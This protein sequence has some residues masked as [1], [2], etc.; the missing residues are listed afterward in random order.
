MFTPGIK[1]RRIRDLVGNQRDVLRW[2][3]FRGKPV[4]AVLACR[5]CIGAVCVHRE[6]VGPRGFRARGLR[7]HYPLA[8][9]R[10]PALYY[11]SRIRRGLRWRALHF[12]FR[13][14]ELFFTHVALACNLNGHSH[15]TA[16]VILYAIP[17]AAH[18]VRGKLEVISDIIL[19]VAFRIIRKSLSTYFYFL[20]TFSPFSGYISDVTA[21]VSGERYTTYI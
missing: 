2:L 5:R 16:A 7:L 6:P 3:N 12:C 21:Y 14:L 20:R 10:P 15:A 19:G 13:L 1:H 11:P 17:S 8:P 18:L 4:T 9:P